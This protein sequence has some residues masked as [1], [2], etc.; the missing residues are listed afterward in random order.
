MRTVAGWIAIA[1]LLGAACGS[2]ESIIVAA[3][4]T[5]VDSTFL[6]PFIEKFERET[7]YDVKLIAAGSGE[8]LEMGRRGEVDVL[9]THDPAGEEQFMAEGRGIQRY[10]FIRNDFLIAGPPGDSAGIRGS[11]ALEAFRR[12]K[13]SPFASRDDQSGTHKKEQALAKAAGVELGKRIRV[14]AG[15]A[16]TLRAADERRAYILVDSMTF[17]HFRPTLDLEPLVQ[18]DSLLANPYSII[19]VKPLREDSS[20][21][22]RSARR[23]SGANLFVSMLLKEAFH[24]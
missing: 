20:G 9:I 13:D 22:N 24:R 7:G 12:M 10:P 23:S 2:S 19:I 3:G 11:G 18:G 15:V 21:A 4:T 17:S 1:A 14:G 5:L 8:G 6:D 16:I